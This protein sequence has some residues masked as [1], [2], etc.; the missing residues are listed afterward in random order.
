MNVITEKH[1]E[2]VV[3]TP[4]GE[5]DFETVDDLARALHEAALNEPSRL[6]IDMSDVSFW[7][8]TAL[9]VLLEAQRLQLE[10]DGE[11]VLVVPPGPLAS[12]MEEAGFSREIPTFASFEEAIATITD[13]STRPPSLKSP[14]ASKIKIR[15]HNGAAGAARRFVRSRVSGLDPVRKLEAE[16]LVTEVVTN[17]LTHNTVSPNDRISIEAERHPGSLR[18]TVESQGPSLQESIPGFGLRL[19]EKVARAWGHD[20]HD[21]RLLVWFELHRP[22]G[23]LDMGDLNDLETLQRAKTDEG[24]KAEVFKRYQPM[25]HKLSSDFRGKVAETEDLEQVAAMALMGAIERFDPSAGSFP[26][27]ASVTIT[28]ELKRHLRDRGW[29]VRVPRSLQDSALAVGRAKLHLSQTLQRSPTPEEIG[30]ETGMSPKQVIEAEEAGAAYR[31]DSLNAPL[32]ESDSDVELIDRL[33]D[34]DGNLNRVE[35]WQDLEFVM[36]EL[37]DRD[38]TVLYLR[39]FEDKT[40]S[41][42]A[43]V[44]GISQMHVSRILSRSIK[45]LRELLS[46]RSLY[47]V[48]DSAP[49]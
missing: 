2:W 3:I 25:V 27:F 26:A 34:A 14:E 41:E 36:K 28:G 13:R 33:G 24:A 1:R 38:R 16:L 23:A 18:F 49:G 44:M 9:R 47:A 37:S 43:A 19:L 6:A 30:L 10:H 46:D 39:F 40:Q 42:I 20:Y 15:P 22:G 45:A 4:S 31:A 35:Q 17:V 12:M 29:S 11:L 7:D 32:S 8:S 21:G 5:I 48:S